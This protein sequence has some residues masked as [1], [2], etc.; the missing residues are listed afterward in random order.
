MFTFR[1]SPE[2]D[3]LAL[4]PAVSEGEGLF[5]LYEHVGQ[6]SPASVDLLTEWETPTWPEV[7]PLYEELQ[8][9]GYLE[10][11]PVKFGDFLKIPKPYPSPN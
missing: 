5:S 8:S 11:L 9:I 6:H 7:L 1:K 2:G 10:E 4:D 3:I